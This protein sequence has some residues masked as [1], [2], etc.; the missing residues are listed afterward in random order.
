MFHVDG[1]DVEQHVPFDSSRY[2]NSTNAFMYMTSPSSPPRNH[3]HDRNHLKKDQ[4][5]VKQDQTS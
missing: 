2:S 3:T 5:L 4:I 1:N